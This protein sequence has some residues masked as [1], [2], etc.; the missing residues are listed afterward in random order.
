MSRLSRK[1]MK[2]D[3]VME[4]VGGFFE[5]GRDHAKTILWSV[6]AVI[7]LALAVVAWFAYQGGR[8]ERSAE[9]LAAALRVFGA[10]VDPAAADPD[11]ARAPVFADDASRVARARELFEQ[12]RSEH[13]GTDA[14]DLA[15]AYLGHLD[16][17]AGNLD[18]AREHWES[19]LDRQSEH[20][21]AA[22]VSL[23]LMALDR[24]QGRSEQLVDEL[25]ARLDDPRETLPEEV[26]LNE[27]GLTL[28]QLDRRAEAREIYGRIVQEYPQS[29]FFGRAQ[30]QF[31]ALEGSS[32]GL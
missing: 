30:R 1:E 32:T 5:Y 17:D 23:N 27:L 9:S 24:V 25:R 4:T 7:V 6:A 12:I 15:G 11:N 28:E 14:A 22:E 16:A 29:P 10:A 3:E 21:L 26:L 8:E 2:R 31:E 20:L 18:G 13:G 19:F